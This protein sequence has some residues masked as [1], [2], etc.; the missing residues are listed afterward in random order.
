MQKKFKVTIKSKDINN[1]EGFINN[2]KSINTKISIEQYKGY[3]RFVQLLKDLTD[4]SPHKVIDY[5]D[6]DNNFNIIIDFKNSEE[7]YNRTENY[8]IT[9][10]RLISESLSKTNIIKNKIYKNDEI[11]EQYKELFPLQINS[12]F[13]GETQEEKFLNIFNNIIVE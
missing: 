6:E 13:I 2:I 1:N 4:I 7:L 11:T 8:K 9:L 12:C 5:L 10:K 3:V